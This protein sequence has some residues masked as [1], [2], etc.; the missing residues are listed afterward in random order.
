MSLPAAVIDYLQSDF[1]EAS[2]PFCVLIDSD[3]RLLDSWGDGEWAGLAGLTVGTDMLDHAPYLLG[4]LDTEPRKLDHV[5]T[6]DEVVVHLITIPEQDNHYAVFLDASQSHDFLQ[7]RQQASNE[8]RLLHANQQKL[9]ARQRDLIAELVEAKAELDHHR[10]DIERASAG[11]SRFIAMMS[12][13]FRTPLAS[14]IN[15]AD[16]ALEEKSGPTEIQ[17][18]I[19]AIARSGR[20]LTSLVDAVLDEARLDAGQVTLQERNFDLFELLDDLAAMMA[21]LAAEKGLAYATLVDPDVPKHIRADDVCL[22]QILIN[23]L[24]NAVKFTE[25]GGIQLYVSYNDERLVA[26]VTDTG[27]GISVEDQE[28]IF[29]AFERGSDGRGPRSGAGLGLTITLQLAKLMRG[30][31]SL[32]SLPGQGCTVSVHVPV[33][34]AEEAE[35]QSALSPPDVAAYATQAATVLVCDD[36]EDMLALLEHYLHRAGYALITAATGTEAVAKAVTY[37]PEIVLMDVNVPGLSGIAAAAVLRERS[38]SG[39]IVGLTASKLTEAEKAGFTRCF[40]KPAP[41]QELLLTI[42]SLTHNAAP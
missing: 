19:E 9:I 29:R 7:E 30:E 16:L 5:S 25:D 10:R 37:Q 36:D 40:R 31:I 33:A 15:Y 26:T 39:P 20:H 28:R 18:S 4:T 41:M 35:V 34:L 11:K 42:K 1:V 6:G 2:R 17:K 27:P 24:G 32:D 23:L 3:H 12:H 21:P 22:R 13:E 8:L 14:I 38:Y